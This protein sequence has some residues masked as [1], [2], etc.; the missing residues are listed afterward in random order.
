MAGALYALSSA[1]VS[2]IA[3]TPLLLTMTRR[4]R[5]QA[6][7]QVIKL[8]PQAD[9]VRWRSEHCWIY[10]HRRAGTVYSH[11]FLF[12][13]EAGRVAEL[14]DRAKEIIKN[15]TSTKI[16]SSSLTSAVVSLLSDHGLVTVST[17]TSSV[18]STGK[19][20]TSTIPVLGNTGPWAW[21]PDRW[22]PGP[23]S[24]AAT[25]LPPSASV[26]GFLIGRLRSRFP[27]TTTLLRRRP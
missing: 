25:P 7:V 16:S 27:C 19:D 20:D 1:L 4:C 21:D 6:D 18:T 5:G 8:Q 17:L 14:V 26:E 11:G 23:P 9:Q 13:S 24:P 15:T 10:D 2:Y 22:Q 12:P 3:T